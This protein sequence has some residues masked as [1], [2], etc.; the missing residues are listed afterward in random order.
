M[1][2]GTV[3]MAF[4]HIDYEYECDVCGRMNGYERDTMGGRFICDVC[5]AKLK[6]KK[7]GDEQ[8]GCCKTR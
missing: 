7:N 1:S 4:G 6:D 2:G 5:Y 8:N 3:S